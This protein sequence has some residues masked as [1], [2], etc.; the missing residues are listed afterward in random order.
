VHEV[1]VAFAERL[2]AMEKKDADINA[3][4]ILDNLANYVNFSLDHD[5]LKGIEDLFK[6]L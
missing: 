1:N 6:G 3:L 4:I 2:K 5:R